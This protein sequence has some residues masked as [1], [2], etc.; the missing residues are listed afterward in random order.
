MTIREYRRRA[1]SSLAI[2]VALALALLAQSNL[3]GSGNILDGV[4]VVAVAGSLLIYATRD[5]ELLDDPPLTRKQILL[6]MTVIIF[7]GAGVRLWDLASI[8]QG[9]WFDEAQNGIV[10]TRILSDPSF[11]PIYISDLTQLPAL[12]FYYMGAWIALV[13]SNILAVR[14]ASAAL[15]ILTIPGL[16]LLG[17]ELF[18]QR[19][20]L[21]AAFLLS[22]SRWHVN[23]SRFGMNGIA[24]PCCLVFG[25]YF[26]ARGVR[27]ARERDYAV[28]GAL[29]GI[30]LNTYLAFDIVP[31]LVGIWLV[32]VVVSG[33]LSFIRKN[34]RGLATLALF[35]LIVVAPLLVVALTDRQAFLERT[36]TASLFTGKSLE[37]ATAALVTNV[38]KHVEMFN[39]RGDGNGRHNLAGA[40]EL[41]YLTGALFLLGIILALARARQPRYS[42][43]LLWLVL[44]LLPGILSLDFEAPQSYRSIGVIPVTALLAAVPL[45]TAW[46]VIWR[47]LG[48]TSIRALDLFAGLAVLAAGFINFQVYWFQ[49][50]WDNASWAE[51]STQ[52][53]LVAREVNRLGPG[54][55]VFVDPIFIGL[56]TL[57]F[58][59]PQLKQILPFE[60]ASSLPFRGSANVVVFSS[61]AN[62]SWINAVHEDYPKATFRTFAASPVAPAILYEAILSS[63]DIQSV[64]GLNAA[65]ASGTADDAKHVFDRVDKS[66]DFHW[67]QTTP[68]P[69]PFVVTW[70]GTLKTP[71]FGD[72]V[73]R[74]DGPAGAQLTLDQAPAIGAGQPGRIKLAEGTHDIQLNAAFSAP[75]D[76]RLSWQPPGGLLQPIPADALFASPVKNRG[77]E[78][79]FYPNANWTGPPTIKQIDPD[80][81]KHYHDLPLAQPFTVEWNGKLDVPATGLYRFGTQSIDS[82]WLWIDGKQVVNNSRGPDQYVEGALS[83][84]NGLHDLKIRLLD[85]TGHSFIDVY[86]Q[87]PG[88]PRTLLPGDRAFPPLAAY[89]ER[90][91]A[92]RASQT[93]YVLVTGSSYSPPNVAPAAGSA[94]APAA[95]VPA[96]S[97]EI[98]T[99]PVSPLPV[100][101]KFG[102]KGNGPNQLVE[103]RGVA[104]NADGNV[105]I[106]DSVGK[107]V[108]LFDHAGKLLHVIGGPGNGDGQFAEPVAA[109][110]DTAGNL[111]VLDSE[112]AWV[113]RFGPD[114]QFSGKFGGPTA[115]FYHPRGIAVDGLGNVYLA[116]TGTGRIIVFNSGGE[117]AK[118]LGEHGQ[119]L[120]QLQEPVGV[121]VAGDGSIFVTDPTAKR[122]SRYDAAF[123]LVSS[124]DLTPTDTV[125]AGHVAVA[126]DGNVYVSDPANHRII[127]LDPKG[128]PVDQLGGEGT[129]DRPV[130]VAVDSNGHVFVADS[131]LDQAFEFGQ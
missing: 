43:L 130:G 87:P 40:P 21:L 85:E 121:A 33:R 103:S 59:A 91:G 124:W 92:L 84:T 83:L 82:S 129:L 68:L 123:Q 52:P 32:H 99:L 11:K 34:W 76:V 104:I 109:T 16:Y 118:A 20:G 71:A 25:L 7:A 120:G 62:V 12:F 122:L 119:K 9:V 23:F 65:Y 114:G 107:R 106:V 31:I 80:I 73:F 19:V 50:I 115:G 46:Q 39:V 112:S 55:T 57:Q 88:A 72:Y 63:Q 97:T 38:V 89:P 8:P 10:A 95:P 18:S 117:Q 75:G 51:F 64:Q 4:I 74:L 6:V 86:W 77:L 45:A 48:A 56:P 54:Y 30:G 81:S 67:S 79:S 126:S 102:E 17:R 111:L 1:R 128:Q 125:I 14:L 98:G 42:L 53:T 61:D 37:Q 47:W 94:E 66:I 41:D 113:Q 24:A 110:F 15:G 26:L 27:T 105:A 28:A 131:G 36:Q 35:A 116:D 2:V 90:A 101:Q 5:V 44:L 96:D 29:F 70:R 78:A 108:E 93:P 60:P 127:H 69:A 100:T 13:G 58:L 49:Q 3:L 22:Q